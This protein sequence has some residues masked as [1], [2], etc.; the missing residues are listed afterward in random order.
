MLACLEVLASESR[1]RILALVAKGV[2]HPEDLAKKLKLRRQ[3]V[4]KQ[5]MELYD[6]GFVD[7]SAM[8]P[9]SGRPRIVYRLSGRGLDLIA[10]LDALMLEYREGT[11]A[12]YQQSVNVLENKLASG[13]V[14]EEAYLKARA[15]LET[16]YTR[17]LPE[18][19]AK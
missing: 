3:G 11:A 15:S 19:K 13:E 12:D 8:I 2:D 18:A 7:R 4:D 9:A 6:W 1:Q 10:R 17:F 16:R 5:L 14:D